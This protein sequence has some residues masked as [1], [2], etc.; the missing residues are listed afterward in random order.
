MYRN[1]TKYI[2]LL[3]IT[4]T[5]LLA[6]P[7]NYNFGS[8]TG[9]YTTNAI[10]TTFLPT[11]PSGGTLARVGS[12]SGSVNLENQIIP[13]GSGSY[14]RS[15]AAT[16]TSVNKF[17]VNNYT[18]G[19]SFTIKFDLRF[20]A[21]D[22]SSTGATNGNW[23]FFMGDGTMYTDGGGFAGAQVFS[24]LRFRFGAG[25]TI[26][27]SFRNRGNW[28]STTVSRTYFTQG[29]TYQ[30]EIYG[31]NNTS[32][33]TYDYGSV[34]SLDSN[35]Y[36]IWIDGVLFAN[37]IPKAQLTNNANIDSW[38]FYGESSVGN[39]ANIFTDNFY[40]QNGLAGT[41]LPVT[42]G[43][44]ELMAINR[45]AVLSWSTLNEINN[46]GF[47]VERCSIEGN[48]ETDWI[49]AGFV[50]GHGTTNETKTY[51]FEDKGL[52][53]GQYKYRLKQIDYNGN[54]E[55][56]SPS[57]ASIVNITRPAEF[58]VSQNYPNPSNPVSK[59][60]YEVPFDGFVNI[61][62]YDVTGKAVKELVNGYQ[63]ADYYSITFD[64]SSLATGVYFYR[65]TGSFG[66]DK[67]IQTKKMMLIK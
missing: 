26:F 12:G 28:D 44:F 59:I 42:L 19:K 18:A 27:F 65:V 10:S 67:F 1:I 8:S 29:Q 36:D 21:S 60:D 43:S 2:I 41:P 58:T 46:S 61:T 11:P 25:G 35:K 50:N 37:D 32:S 23:Y 49:A 4:F 40:Y 7:W 31:N 47:F 63:K 64:G 56:F 45:S 14:I 9:I 33:L 53:T 5:P 54:F 16:G 13:F 30:V 57:N 24:G 22:G 62:V 48:K 38:V 6:Q 39:S 3:S 51:N 55:Y 20:G 34:Q 15:A 66:E 17:G 52:R